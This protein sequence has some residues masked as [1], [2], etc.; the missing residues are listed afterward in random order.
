V[1][2]PQVG[3]GPRHA[4]APQPLDRQTRRKA[5]QE[6]EPLPPQKASQGALNLLH[7]PNFARQPPLEVGDPQSAPNARFPLDGQTQPLLVPTYTR[8]RKK[9]TEQEVN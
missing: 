4:P 2:P 9:L 7:G 5:P 3:F 1:E 8:R 6:H